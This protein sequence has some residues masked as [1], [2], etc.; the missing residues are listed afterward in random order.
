MLFRVATR[1]RD[2]GIVLFSDSS[3]F[4][5]PAAGISRDGYREIRQQLNTLISRYPG[6]V[7]FIHGQTGSLTKGID[8]R[9]RLG[10]LELAPDWTRIEVNPASNVVFKVRQTPPKTSGQRK[11]A[12]PASR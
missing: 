4:A 11:T 7:L 3:P 10:L 9:G 5:P 2:K 6:K 1:R 8:W 12:K